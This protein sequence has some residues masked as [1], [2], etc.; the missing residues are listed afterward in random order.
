M[1]RKLAHTPI[2]NFQQWPFRGLFATIARRLSAN[3][4]AITAAGVRMRYARG[5]REIQRMVTA[6]V[7]RRRNK[8]IPGATSSEGCAVATVATKEA[9][10]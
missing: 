9:V 3:G 6:E 8:Y 1:S 5:N 10:R 4:D 2:V 7:N